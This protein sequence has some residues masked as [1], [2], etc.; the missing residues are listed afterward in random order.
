M[1]GPSNKGVR[2]NLRELRKERGLSLEAL[3]VL[4]EVDIASLSRIER[5]RQAP[6]PETVVRLAKGLGIAARRMQAILEEP[7]EPVGV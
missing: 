3:S 5:G 7:S 4:S 2:V 6:R 1:N